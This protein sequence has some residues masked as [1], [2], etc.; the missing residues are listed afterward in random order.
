MKRLTLAL[1]LPLMAAS[2]VLLSCD[3]FFNNN[4]GDDKKEEDIPVLYKDFYKYPAGKVDTN[5]LLT[6]KNS[7][8][9]RVLL[10]TDSVSGPN[11]I[12]TV[13]GLGSVKVKLSEEKFYTIVAVDK[14]NYEEKKEQAS[15]F[16]DFT[17]YS[18]RQPYLMTVSPTDMSGAGTWIITNATSYW[19]AMNKTDQSGGNWA[20]VAPNAVRTEIPIP[21]GQ[22]LRY[23]PHFY[24]ELKHNGKVIALVE[25]DMIRGADTVTTTDDH[26]TFYTN[27]GQNLTPPSPNLQPAVYFTNSSDKS[28]EV[29][30]GLQNKLSPGGQPGE[31]FVMGSGWDQM[32]TQGISAGIS[33]KTINFMALGWDP[34]RVYVSQDMSMQKDKVYRIVLSGNIDQGYSTTVTEEDNS[35]YFN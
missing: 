20:V 6:I 24:K 2:L 22:P 8:N 27:I 9:S 7:V 21:I 28:V 19:V 25:S 18:N 23:I 11:Y 12:G 30:A 4:D 13:E 29:F 15:Q 5:G 34:P 26:P 3:D 16:S 32:F 31:D 35:D 17:F 33:T 10:F 1:W 14:T